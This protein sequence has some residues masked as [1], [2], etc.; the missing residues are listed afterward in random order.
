[1]ATSYPRGAARPHPLMTDADRFKLLGTYRTP[2][3]RAGRVLSARPA[4]ATA[5]AQVC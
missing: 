5:V 1:M 3:V 2:R 4:T